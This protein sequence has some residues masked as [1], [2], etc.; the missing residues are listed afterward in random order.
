MAELLTVE[1]HVL[2]KTPYSESSLIIA[3]LSDQGQQH[4]MLRGAL[5]IGKRNFPA[6]DLF[7]RVRIIYRPTTRSDLHTGRDAECIDSYAGIPRHQTH[8][9][10]AA[11]LSRMILDNTA[12]NDPAPLLHTAATTA[13]Q[14][15]GGD[16]EVPCVPVVLGVGF[17]LLQEAGSLPSF[18]EQ[19]DIRQSVQ[20]MIACAT[21]AALP[22]P[23]YTAAVW[24]DLRDW[25]Q[26]F[27]LQHDY[28]VPRDIEKIGV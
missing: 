24:L 2:R 13:F 10:A 27:L 18:D 8:Y 26:A 1:G 7:R 19:P 3:L 21:S 4:F 20:R 16:E 5:K 11:W 28:K 17:V 25:L 15:L 6:V 9:R 14:R 23:D 12:I 22:Y